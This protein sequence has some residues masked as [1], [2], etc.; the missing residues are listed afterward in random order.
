MRLEEAEQKV[1]E[2]NGWTKEELERLSKQHEHAF[3]VHL[4]VDGL[5][6]MYRDAIK[7][8]L[9]LLPVVEIPETLKDQVR[10]RNRIN[11]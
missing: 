8:V 10:N 9:P 1:L 3:E 7:G 6:M 5:N 2:S 4:R 11:S